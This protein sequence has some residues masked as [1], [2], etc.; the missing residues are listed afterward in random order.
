MRLFA[1]R[2]IGRR[3]IMGVSVNPVSGVKRTA[4]SIARTFPW[5]VIVFYIGAVVC[6][7]VAVFMYF[8]R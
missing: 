6:I 5:A 4:A 1:G 3:G 7:C 2:R 8:R